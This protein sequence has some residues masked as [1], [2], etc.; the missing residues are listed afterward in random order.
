MCSGLVMAIVGGSVGNGYAIR[1]GNTPDY[2]S[3]RATESAGAKRGE[4]Y[5]V[6][7]LCIGD[8]NQ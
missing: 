3:I 6:H 8:R 5:G 1:Q 4:E 7:C 2:R